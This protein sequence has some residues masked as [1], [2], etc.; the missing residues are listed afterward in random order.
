MGFLLLLYILLL[1]ICSAIGQE[2]TQKP[3]SRKVQPSAIQ[4]TDELIEA[5]RDADP[6]RR[7][8]AAHA[9][10]D[11]GPHARKAVPVLIE[12]SDDDAPMVRG[13]PLRR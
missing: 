9:L 13:Q 5:L 4:D 6:D 12:A 7:E 3:I 11:I 8:A 10:G 1:S 2:K